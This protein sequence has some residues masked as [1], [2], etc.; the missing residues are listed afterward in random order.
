VEILPRRESNAALAAGG[1]VG[2]VVAVAASA[3]GARAGLAAAVGAL[4]FALAWL[5]WMRRWLGR[6]WQARRSLDPQVRATLARDVVFY[7]RLDPARRALFERRVQ[8]FL[9]EHTLTAPR[10]T[11]VDRATQALVAAS[12]VILL[13]G[14]DDLELPRQMDIVVYEDAF[15]EQYAI[16]HRGHLLGQVH[17]Q[18]PVI[19]SARALREGF[20]RSADGE[21]VGLHEFAHLLDLQGGHFDGVP[22]GMPWR[23]AGPWLAMVHREMERIERHQSLLRGYGAENEAEFFAVAVESFFERPAQLREQ[24]AEL[25]A[26]LRE[27]LG[28]DPAAAAAE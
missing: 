20:R 21:H 3:L 6:W 16:S 7:Q 17:G 8:W 19:L 13:F 1:A 27:F 23:A 12:A 28:Q 14:R 18:G 9:A 26:A 2:L 22:S 24:H 5:G 25:Y 4:A 11:T 10:G 15:D